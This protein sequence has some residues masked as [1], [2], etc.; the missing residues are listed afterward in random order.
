MPLVIEWLKNMNT[1]RI[2]ISYRKK[3]INRLDEARE[4][5]RNLGQFNFETWLDEDLK[6]GDIWRS[7]IDEALKW[8]NCFLLV[9]HGDIHSGN[10]VLEEI[11]FALQA[12]SSGKYR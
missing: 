12:V 4:I 6:G 1:P 3:D 9:V 2:F 5:R 11:K 7:E 8:A 10:T